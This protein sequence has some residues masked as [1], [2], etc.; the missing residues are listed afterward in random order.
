MVW[1]VQNAAEYVLWTTERL[2]KLLLFLAA[3]WDAG[4]MKECHPSR[5]GQLSSLPGSETKAIKQSC[6]HAFLWPPSRSLISPGRRGGPAYQPYTSLLVAWTLLSYEAEK[7]A[8]PLVFAR[9]AA[10]ACK[11]C[12]TLKM[13]FQY[14][15][16]ELAG[17]KDEGGFMFQQNEVFPMSGRGRAGRVRDRAWISH[18]AGWG[19][20]TLEL[21]EGWKEEEW[22][23]DSYYNHAFREGLVR[24]IKQSKFELGRK[25]FS[26]G[27][28]GVLPTTLSSLLKTGAC[29]YSALQR[30]VTNPSWS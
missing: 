16:G 23:R 4:S 19:G 3:W 11:M 2:S 1:S 20:G 28:K 18:S 21:G 6:H 9:R 27:L 30:I 25:E 15:Q 24:W 5:W 26:A 22:W 13:W 10:E 17:D 12:R 7:R 8:C 29:I 14:G